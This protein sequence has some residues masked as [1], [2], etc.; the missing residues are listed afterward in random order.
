VQFP[1]VI[2]AREVDRRCLLQGEPEGGQATSQRRCDL[3]SEQRL[4]SASMLQRRLKVG[5]NRAANLIEE[6][7]NYNEFKNYLTYPY[8]NFK[9]FRCVIN[10]NLFFF[11][12]Q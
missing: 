10:S 1:F 5:Y 3:L 2:L 11:F 12:Y 8:I 6:M 7:E 4:A 9:D